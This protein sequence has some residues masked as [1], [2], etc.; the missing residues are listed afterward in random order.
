MNEENKIL[1]QLT[2]HV[3][4]A[5]NLLVY[6]V[7]FFKCKKLPIYKKC[8]TLHQFQKLEGKFHL[9]VR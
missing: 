7:F 9:K 5:S 3:N 8:A 1:I 6:A 2:V 4:I